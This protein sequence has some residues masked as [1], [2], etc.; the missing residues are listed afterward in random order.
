MEM[1]HPVSAESMATAPVA[2]LAFSIATSVVAAAAVSVVVAVAAVLHV[3]TAYQL[4]AACVVM[5]QPSATPVRLAIIAAAS[6]TTM[7]LMRLTDDGPVLATVPPHL[8][9]LL[10][11]TMPVSRWRSPTL[12]PALRSCRLAPPARRACH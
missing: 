7:P 11:R 6:L 3:A 10:H 8:K 1:V 9:L 4:V 2:A 5:E 12:A